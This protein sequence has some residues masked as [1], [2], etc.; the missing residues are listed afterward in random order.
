M[1]ATEYH[2]NNPR[3]NCLISCKQQ[4]F[5]TSCFHLFCSFCVKDCVQR[6]FVCGL[7]SPKIK[8]ISLSQNNTALIG[9]NF[10]GIVTAMF[11][12]TRF[13]MSQKDVNIKKLTSKVEQYKRA[14]ISSKSELDSLREENAKLKHTMKQM[15]EDNKQLFLS[16]KKSCTDTKQSVQYQSEIKALKQRPATMYTKREPGFKFN[17]IFNDA[18]FD[19]REVSETMVTPTTCPGKDL[20]LR[21]VSGGSI[22]SEFVNYSSRH[23]SFISVSYTH[24]TLPT[25]CSV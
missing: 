22:R 23:R 18:E 11:S 15:V 21:S 25:I 14:M 6:C 16:V 3:C 8:Q 12:A 19:G 7:V 5:L 10:E 17:T 20:Y 1:Q 2:C 4:C 9:T 13:Q 24:L